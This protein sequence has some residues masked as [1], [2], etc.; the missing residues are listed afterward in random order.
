[1]AIPPSYP[2]YQQP[3]LDP[4]TGRVTQPWQLFFLSLTR[5]LADALVDGSVTFV[6]LEP[7]ASPRL[8][9]RGSVGTGPVEQLTLGT[10]LAMTGTVLEVTSSGTAALG[11]W[12]P[13]TNGDPVSPEILFDAAGDCVVGFVPTP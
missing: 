10:G 6:K 5:G 12:T 8:L 2:P 11:Y 1:M 7:I 9:G 13:I 3:L 4:R